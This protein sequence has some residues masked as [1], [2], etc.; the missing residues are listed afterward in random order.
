MNDITILDLFWI[1]LK[2]LA[3]LGLVG[4]IVLALYLVWKAAK[5]AAKTAWDILRGRNTSV[6]AIVCFSIAVVALVTCAVLAVSY[7]NQHT[8]LVH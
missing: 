1:I 8:N 7:L 5:A 2:F 4:L 6:A 3:A